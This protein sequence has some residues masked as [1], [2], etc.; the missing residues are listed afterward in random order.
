MNL[1]DRRPLF[2]S[3]L[4]LLA[5]AIL[6][7]V[8][9]LHALS[10]PQYTAEILNVPGA[11][12]EILAGP[13]DE[14]GPNWAGLASLSAD[15]HNVSGEVLSRLP[16]R[17]AR[18]SAAGAGSFSY[19]WH[20][21]TVD[22]GPDGLAPG[23]TAHL[24]ITLPMVV[25][26]VAQRYVLTP[27]AGAGP[28]PV[29]W[30]KSDFPQLLRAIGRGDEHPTVVVELP[31]RLDERPA[32]KSACAALRSDADASCPWGLEQFTCVDLASG[33]P[34]TTATCSRQPLAVRRAAIEAPGASRATG[35]PAVRR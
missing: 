19:D 32:G 6:L 8:A 15:V 10:T 30:E 27:A 17:F 20:G 18:L 33:A 5:A 34:R 11:P 7:P 23:G 25:R 31:V 28:D 9:G 22:L 21:F 29:G 1:T 26:P 3:I 13:R 24:L 2:L 4:G 16:L 12:F 14:S 35:A